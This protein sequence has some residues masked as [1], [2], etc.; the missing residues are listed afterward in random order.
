MYWYKSLPDQGIY[1][2]LKKRDSASAKLQRTFIEFVIIGFIVFVIYFLL[3]GFSYMDPSD[4]CFLKIKYD[5][6]RGDRETIVEALKRLKAED[7]V[8]YRKFCANVNIIYERRCTSAKDATPDIE[9]IQ[10]DG[11]YIQGSHAIIIEPIGEGHHG[12]VDRRIETI[13]KYGGMAIKYW[14]YDAPALFSTN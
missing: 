11:C 14:D 2:D 5:V 10:T 4:Q 7:Y 9:F 12:S 1:D 13:K 8:F 3:S 6:L